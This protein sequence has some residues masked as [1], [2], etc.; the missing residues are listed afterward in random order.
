MSHPTIRLP[1]YGT[2]LAG[3]PLAK[4][5]VA[6]GHGSNRVRAARNVAQGLWREAFTGWGGP[7]NGSLAFQGCTGCAGTTPDGPRTASLRKLAP[8]AAGAAALRPKF[9][10][11]S[12][13]SFANRAT[14]VAK[15][16]QQ[17]TVR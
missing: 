6:P 12:F 2:L 4:A 15:I 7:A 14:N 1:R 8:V 9:T 10:K 17:G 13:E 3:I 16:G 11:S 5:Y